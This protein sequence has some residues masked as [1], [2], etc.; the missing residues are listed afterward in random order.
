MFPSLL[1]LIGGS[2]KSKVLYSA[3]TRPEGIW[4]IQVYL[5]KQPL[6]ASNSSSSSMLVIVVCYY[7]QRMRTVMV[8][9]WRQC[10]TKI[11][12]AKLTPTLNR[13][14]VMLSRLDNCGLL[15][16]LFEDASLYR[17]NLYNLTLVSV[18]RWF[19]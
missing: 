18:L 19:V 17:R 10:H 7:E 8:E 12:D 3:A 13:N 15:F 6:R 4:L 5:E 14:D 11:G 9:R 16:E 1:I 2:K